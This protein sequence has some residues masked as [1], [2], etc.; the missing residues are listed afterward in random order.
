MQPVAVKS[1]Q[2]VIYVNKDYAEDSL[3][4]PESLGPIET[5]ED[6][7]RLLT[8]LGEL[9]DGTRLV[10]N[11]TNRIAEVAKLVRTLIQ[12]K[13]LEILVA[14]STAYKQYLNELVE[15]R[16]VAYQIGYERGMKAGATRARRKAK[17]Q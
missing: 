4:R 10:F 1:R 2:D 11:E 6:E 13:N 17:E 14:E 7:V 8:Y 15:G 5:D 9:A 3:V 12:R 16:K